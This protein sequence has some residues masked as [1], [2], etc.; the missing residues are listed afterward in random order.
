MSYPYTPPAGQPGQPGQAPPTPTTYP[1]GATYLPATYTAYGHPPTPGATYAPYGAAH[2]AYQ[3]GVTTYGWPYQYSYIPQH[4]QPGA[5]P[6][7]PA[8][9]VAAQTP[10]AATPSVA[11]PTTT[12]VTTSA[13]PATMSLSQPQQRT[14][15]TTF[16]TYTPYGQTQT[17]THARETVTA[18]ATAGATG[19]GRKQ[20]NFKGMFTKELKSLMYGF[21]DDRNPANDTVNVME[22]ILIEYIT[23]VVRLCLSLACPFSPPYHHTSYVLSPFG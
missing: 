14:S 12:P 22:E 1:Y 19:R 15:T 13:V 16:S 4:T 8:K 7:T 3:S 5:T 18:A 23:D 10:V 2:S 9:P 20:A 6:S 17:Q 21:G 11:T